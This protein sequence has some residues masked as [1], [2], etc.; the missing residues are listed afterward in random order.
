MGKS[1]KKKD[2]G[3]VSTRA[4]LLQALIDGPG[5]GLELTKRVKERTKG[6]MVIGQGRLYPTLWD[7]QED[8]LVTCYETDPVPERGGRPRKYYE[9][10]AEGLRSAREE[11][12]VGFLLFGVPEPETVS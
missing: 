11:Q 10:T 5:Y 8:G 1:K 7:L 12:V 3:P 6:K 4:A 9:L 2:R